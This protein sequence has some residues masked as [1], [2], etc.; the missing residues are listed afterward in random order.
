MSQ[1]CANTLFRTSDW[2]GSSTITAFQQ[3]VPPDEIEEDVRIP[4]WRQPWAGSVLCGPTIT[5]AI[6][7]FEPDPG[8]DLVTYLTSRKSQRRYCVLD[9][10]DALSFLQYEDFEPPAPVLSLKPRSRRS[11]T[12]KVSVRP[13]RLSLIVPETLE[14]AE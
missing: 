11:V 14:E 2:H 3:T 8:S 1:T 6:D 4:D 12:A 7:A 10:S 9:M 13:G 5:A